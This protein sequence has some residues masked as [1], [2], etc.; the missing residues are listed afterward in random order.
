MRGRP[1][2]GVVRGALSRT[3]TEERVKEREYTNLILESEELAEFDYTPSKA[4]KT[5][6]MVV[7]KKNILEEKGQQCLG[8]KVRYFFYI[9]NDRSL[10]LAEIVAESNQRCNQENLLAQLKGGVRSLHSPLKTLVANWAYMV[11]AS[12]AWTLKAWFALL[13]PSS[14]RWKDLHDEQREQVLRMEFRT[15]LNEFM[16]IPAQILR[17]GRRLIYRFL[18]WRPSMPVFF[19]LL[20]AL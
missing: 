8:N 17:S 15:F 4:T 9:T 2:R 11:I 3:D 7:L 14:P 16:L 6:R 19:R 12:L 18:A 10:S 13:L 1:R 5:Y 20:D